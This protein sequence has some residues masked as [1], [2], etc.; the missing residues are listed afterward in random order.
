MKK[1]PKKKFLNS[2]YNKIQVFAEKQINELKKIRS[3]K[4]FKKRIAHDFLFENVF[5]FWKDCEFI[6][7][8]GKRKKGKEYTPAIMRMALEKCVKLIYLTRK[9]T[10][11][12]QD[13][14]VELEIM[15]TCRRYYWREVKDGKNT[16]NH[17]ENFYKKV[18]RNEDEKIS[19]REGDINSFPGMKKMLTEIFHDGKE[20]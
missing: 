2:F 11:S 15:R 16:A 14:L 5:S 1:Q 18:K 13:R 10:E 19:E 17:W 7:A 4:N 12:D 8:L 6:I 20:R 3:N 9:T